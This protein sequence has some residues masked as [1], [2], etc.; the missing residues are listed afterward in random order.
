MDERSIDWSTAKVSDD[1]ILTVELRGS[2]DEAWDAAFARIAEVWGSE[3]RGQSW[4]DVYLVGDTVI[5][6]DLNDQTAQERLQSYLGE[7]VDGAN[8]D[9]AHERIRAAKEATAR[10]RLEGE[11]V[12]AAQR[13]T[14]R[15]RSIPG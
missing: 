3:T 5:V 4:G 7:A 15:F 12:E 6:H 13:L 10:Q 1:L 11:R 9:A 8:R 14:D 2:T